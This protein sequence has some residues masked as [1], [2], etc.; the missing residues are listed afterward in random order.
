MLRYFTQGFDA[1]NEFQEPISLRQNTSYGSIRKLSPV[2]FRLLL[3]CLTAEWVLDVMLL[4][5]NSAMLLQ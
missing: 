2:I 3:N 1:E 4:V 5:T